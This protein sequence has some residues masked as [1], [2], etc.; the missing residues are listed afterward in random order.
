MSEPMIV[1]KDASNDAPQPI[2]KFSTK[3]I[4]DAHTRW[5]I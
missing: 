3:M 4:E 2:L 5:R 1:P